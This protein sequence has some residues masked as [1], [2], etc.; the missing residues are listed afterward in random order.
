MQI[1]SVLWKDILKIFYYNFIYKRIV[2]SIF[3]LKKDFI[4]LIKRDILQIYSLKKDFDFCY[5]M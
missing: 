3:I 1:I 4:I 5:Y 2:D